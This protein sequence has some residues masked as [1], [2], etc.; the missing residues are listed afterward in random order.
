MK[1][2]D[3]SKYVDAPYMVKRLDAYLNY[4]GEVQYLEYITKPEFE[5][6]LER[7]I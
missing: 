4:N 2:E 7:L 1:K 3:L 5:I 6:K